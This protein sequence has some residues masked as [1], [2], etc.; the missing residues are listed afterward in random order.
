[1][2]A[3]LD[4]TLHL[5]PYSE[6]FIEA[7]VALSNRIFDHADISHVRWRMSSM[8]DNTAMARVNLVHGFTVCGMWSYPERNQ[9]LFSKNLS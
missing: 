3:K 9:I 4:C 1:M 2:P 8:P 5:P 6:D 7:L